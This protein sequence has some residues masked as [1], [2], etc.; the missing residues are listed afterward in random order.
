MTGL[1]YTNDSATR[2]RVVATLERVHAY[3]E[4]SARWARIEGR[5]TE[6]AELEALQD[7]AAAALAAIDTAENPSEGAERVEA[8]ESID[9][10]EARGDREE[11]RHA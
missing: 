4:R 11:R 7:E 2:D 6:A 9:W 8:I 10:S 5:R 3:A 1:A